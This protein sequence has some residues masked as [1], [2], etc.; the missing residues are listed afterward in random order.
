MPILD[1]K[2]RLEE[3]GEVA[4]PYLYLSVGE[5]LGVDALFH[6]VYDVLLSSL[7]G[8]HV[9]VGHAGHGSVAET[10][11]TAIARGTHAIMLCRDAVVE[12]TLQPALMDEVGTL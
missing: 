8:Q 11:S 1:E 12:V 7:A 9:G 2:A 10:L 4:G 5:R 6:T 3:K